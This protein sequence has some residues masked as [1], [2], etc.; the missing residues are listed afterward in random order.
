MYFGEG[1]EV[2]DRTSIITAPNKR[3]I[4][5]SPRGDI[6]ITFTGGQYLW[7][8]VPNTMSVNKVTSSGF[9]VPMEAPVNQTVNGTYKCYRSADTIN[10]GTVKFTI[11]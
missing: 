10:E 5:S 1:G 6:S 7:L 11:S 4:A 2:F 8:C 9:A 3:P